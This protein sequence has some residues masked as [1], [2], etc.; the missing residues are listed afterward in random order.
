M[1][2]IYESESQGNHERM[3][4]KKSYAVSTCLVS[5]GRNGAVHREDRYE[6]EKEGGHPDDPVTLELIKH[7]FDHALCFLLIRESGLLT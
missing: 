6:T 4:E 3:L 7:P 2:V 5:Q 1:N